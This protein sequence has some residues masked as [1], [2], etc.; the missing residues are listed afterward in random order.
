MRR[1]ES[2]SRLPVGRLSPVI[3]GNQ[4]PVLLAKYGILLCSFHHHRVQ[5]D[6]WEIFF[7]D[8]VPYFV[9]PPYIDPSRRPRRGGR[10]DLAGLRV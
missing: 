9:P 1:R 3:K 8:G 10:L 7:R 6:G 5:E 2:K 4:T